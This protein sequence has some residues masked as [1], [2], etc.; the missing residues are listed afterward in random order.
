[1]VLA[2]VRS[3]QHHDWHWFDDNLPFL[4]EQRIF[5]RAK[6]TWIRMHMSER[7]WI[8]HSWCIVLLVKRIAYWYCSG[9]PGPWTPQSIYH[10]ISSK[11]KWNCIQ[12]QIVKLLLYIF[13]HFF[14]IFGSISCSRKAIKL[15]KLERLVIGNWIGK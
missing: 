11:R 2:L 7:F 12:K 14:P 5:W 6:S 3:S 4:R 1:M 10:I 15:H 13:P 8:N 9:H